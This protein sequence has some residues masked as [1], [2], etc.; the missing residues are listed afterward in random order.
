M[1]WMWG[2][3]FRKTVVYTGMVWY[4]LHANGISS[5]VGGRAYRTGVI[6]NAY[7]IL[8]R[9]PNGKP[10]DR[11]YQF[12]DHRLESK[13]ILNR[14]WICVLASSG[15]RKNPAQSTSEHGNEPPGSMKDKRLFKYSAAWSSLKHSNTKLLTCDA[16][17]WNFVHLAA[18]WYHPHGQ[19]IYHQHTPFHA[20]SWLPLVF[21]RLIHNLWKTKVSLWHEHTLEYWNCQKR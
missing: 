16:F 11:T 5:L 19:L 4:V 6:R 1:F 20:L 2:F 9:K 3:I 15:R 10:H 14:V 17:C 8:I 21:N 7:K 13:Q 18:C 12:P